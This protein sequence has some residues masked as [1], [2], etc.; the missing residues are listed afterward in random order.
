MSFRQNCQQLLQSVKGTSLPAGEIASKALILAE[1]IFNTAHELQTSHELEQQQMLA[2]MMDDP[3]GKEFTTAMTDQ[4]FR[5]DNAAR[6]AEQLAYLL[7]IYGIPHFPPPAKRLGLY[8]FRLMGTTLPGLMMP[9]V[10]KFLRSETAQVILPGEEPQLTQ[11]IAKRRG[12]H[13]RVNL[14]HLGEAIL[15]EEEAV[16]RLERY[17]RDL[18]RP[19]V[20][21]ISVKISTIYSQINLLGDEV[22][23]DILSERLRM[24]YR[25]AQ[26]HRYVQLNGESTAK[27]VNLDMEEYRDLHL[28]VTLFC[29]VLEE[30]E[31]LSHSAGI[32]LQSYLPDSFAIQQQLTEWA[33][34]RVKS[35]GAP[36]KIRLVKGANLAMEK[37]EAS[38]RGWPQAP[39]TSKAEV[40][41]NYK[42]MLY[43]GCQYQHARVAHLGIASH[44]LFDISLGLLLRAQHGS[45]EFICFEMLEGMADAIRRAVQL[46]AH[47]MLLYC[48]TATIAEF[49]HGVAY[50]VRRLDENTAPE[51]F[52]RH[53]FHLQPGSPEWQEQA[54]RFMRACEQYQQP[55]TTAQRTQ[56][57]QTE[58]AVRSN[59]AAPFANDPDSDWSLPHNVEWVK[60][61][62]AQQHSSTATAVPLVIAG[63]VITAHSD[64]VGRDPSR[65]GH[66]LYTYAQASGEELERTLACASR[67][68][69]SGPELSA[70]QRA[71]FLAESARLMRQHRGILIGLMVAEGGKT[72][73]E[74]DVEIS[75]AIDFI[76]YYLR[77]M[78]EW[79]NLPHIHWRPKGVVVVAS[80]WNFPC[81]IPVGGI[82]AALAGGN[83]VIFKPANEAILVAWELAQLFWNGGFS[84]EQLQFMP[85]ADEPIGSRLIQDPRV[86]SVILTGG[87]ATAQL[88]LHMRPALDLMAETGGKNSIVITALA[89][90]DLA[91]KELVQSA[92][93]HGGQKCSACSLAI[94]EA[95]VY[96]S[97][98]FRRQLRDAASSMLVGS[99]WELST[100]IPPLIAPPGGS[101]LRALTTLEAGES[102]LLE[103]RQHPDNPHIWSPGI[104]LGVTAGSFTHQTELFGPLLGIMRADNLHHA[105][106]LANGT[107]FGLTAGIHSLDPREQK[108]WIEGIEAGNCY[109]NRTI[110]GAIVQRQPF[111]GCK[112]SSFGPGAKAGG[113]NYI[114][115]MMIPEEEALPQEVEEL[116]PDV[117]AISKWPSYQQL[118]SSDRQRWLASA[119]SYA[120]HWAHYFSN[121]CDPCK[122]MGQHNILRYRPH[123]QL[124]RLNGNE[125][126]V[127]I[128]IIAAAAK[129]VG[130]PLSFSSSSDPFG[131]ADQVTFIIESDQQ[132]LARLSLSARV[133]M[134]TPP[135]TSL[136][137]QLADKGC[138]L[139]VAAPLCC[140]RLELL[141]YLREISLS[142]DHHRYGNISQTLA[143][144]PLG[145]ETI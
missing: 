135:S 79:Q 138:N 37:V 10:K 80:P 118:S 81:S 95:E 50:L 64:I 16:H 51:N 7:K 2:R 76:E 27:F 38:L 101:L 8:F 131:L 139:I 15:G 116:S 33:I 127:D 130:A 144:L 46:V 17:L 25:H 68:S 132:L 40:D 19:D 54:E 87:T 137:Q 45:E 93:G 121:D 100:R 122:L 136:Q 128:L 3:I 58:K 86:N 31:F 30:P 72:V 22:C 6:S 59:M 103:P 106:E 43:Y 140:G 53:L 98:Q 60:Q 34:A 133:R 114:A 36:I 11:H 63:E 145:E 39:Y 97:E 77:S 117:A 74:A 67:I 48:P 41:S 62:L 113:P 52:L 108:L 18:E 126:L 89:D 23:L 92:F 70:I 61:L 111:G 69:S 96:D 14:N 20:E 5:S 47:D 123:K 55:S 71:E 120:Y 75:E 78:L 105:I 35:G 109:I 44:N 49:Q 90:R 129:T 125:Q 99:A 94:V 91:I 107:P 134:A 102:W 119:L 84:R 42:R 1:A 21:Y 24:L 29:R 104:K 66:L 56:N 13:V 83:S 88:F 124:V 28:T 110:T 9:M 65:P 141:R 82:A 26:N 73:A 12:E 32:V 142:I 112:A 85:C 4:C 115:Q 143:A 57:R